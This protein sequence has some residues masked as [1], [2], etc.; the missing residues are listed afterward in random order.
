[1]AFRLAC[2]ISDKIAGIASFA[3]NLGMKNSTGFNC[4]GKEDPNF[5]GQFE[6]N[7]EVCPYEK[8][9]KEFPEHFKCD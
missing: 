1:M 7:K 4:L 5:K 6:W 9:L 8:W 2:E 3:G